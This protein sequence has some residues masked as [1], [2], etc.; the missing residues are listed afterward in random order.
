M[1]YVVLW[2]CLLTRKGFSSSTMYMKI[3]GK[4]NAQLRTINFVC[5]HKENKVLV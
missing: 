5:I 1:C 4:S 3:V 2:N